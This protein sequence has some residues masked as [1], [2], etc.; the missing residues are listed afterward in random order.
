MK[1]FTF[2]GVLDGFRSSVSQS[3]PNT[4]S[5][6]YEQEITENLRPEHF[7]VTKTFCHG[8]P[9]QPTALSYDPILRLL[10]IGTKN[11]GLRILGRP[12]VDV[13]VRHDPDCGAVMHLQF[14][15]NEGFLV[16]AT[17]DDSLHLWNFR[18]TKKP[19]VIQSL[20][21]QRER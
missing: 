19:L 10:A 14:V 2:K 11:G 13:H 16:S 12:G 17:A 20:K 3:G 15:W 9:Y 8:F 5:K 18:A 7:I 21:F 6:S 1:K 4:S